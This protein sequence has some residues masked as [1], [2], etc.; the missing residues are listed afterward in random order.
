MSPEFHG[1]G[2]AGGTFDFV[3]VAEVRYAAAIPEVVVDS[4]PPPI[5]RRDWLWWMPL[6]QAT[7]A[8]AAALRAVAP[9][10]SVY[11]NHS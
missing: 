6:F 3:A 7:A 5:R 11:E 10:S 2:A 1:G 4:G 9:V 8:A